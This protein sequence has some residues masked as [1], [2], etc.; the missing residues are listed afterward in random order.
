MVMRSRVAVIVAVLMVAVAFLADVAQGQAQGTVRRTSPPSAA[1]QPAPSV[2]GVPTVTRTEMA[3]PTGDR[4]TS[5][6]LLERTFPAEVRG[7]Q[8]F[9]YEILLTNLTRRDVY[10][11]ALTEQFPGPFKVATISP[12]PT[13]KEGNLAMWQYNALPGG[14]KAVVRVVGSID[15]PEELTW[16]SR[17]TFNTVLCATTKVV[18]PKLVLTKSAPP[19]VM[20][21]DTIPIR[22]VVS[23]TGSGSMQD[24]RV[25][26]R[27]PQGWR[28]EDGK[29]VVAFDAGTLKAGEAR[30][31]SFVAR[32]AGTGKFTNEATASEAGG[33]T[34][35][36]GTET[37]VSKPVLT[38]S[39]TGPEMR[40]IGRSA[41]YKITVSNTG[42]VA[43]R[44][45]VLVDTITGV[46][47]FVRASD[48]GQFAGGKVTWNLGTLAPK[49][50][51]TVEV[52]LVGQKVGTIRDDAV[53]TAYCAEARAAASTEVKGVAAI[54][55]EV[56][57]VAD[58]IEIGAAETY[59]I[60]VL[61]QGTAYDNN[62]RIEC[63]LPPEL[64]FVSAEGPT[65]YRVAGKSV[66]FE[67]LASL[68]PKATA[69]YRVVVKGTQA[70]DVR[71]KTTLTSDM[72]TSPVEETEST[73]VY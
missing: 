56:V 6:I 11:V 20:V 32:S 14:G 33:L 23:N 37:V 18:E 24:V 67:P 2:A 7:G 21:C 34:A 43:A 1:R 42:E 38:V 66:V 29:D 57:D 25:L 9:G 72:L 65:R 22:L 17:V 28:T 71:F 46:G 68:A 35:K 12:E 61:N 26:D 54:L 55:L 50:S 69:T 30:E 49:A 64:D 44:D 60:T 31:F 47:E 5:V 27:L 16:C 59:V 3:F 45:T 8:G 58:P 39:K 36:A 62:I 41:D 70:G 73:H 40:Y 52:T 13:R 63:T 48:A 10:D 15:R 19:A 51:R 4:A 53:A